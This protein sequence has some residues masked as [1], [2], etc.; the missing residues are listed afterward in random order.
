M[1]SYLKRMPAGIAGAISRP[2]DLTIEPVILDSTNLFAAYGVGGKYS[3]GKF[4]PIASGDT[5]AV[6]A[7]IFVR[8]F[9]TASQPDVVQQI[10]SG[11]NF[12]GDNLKRGYVNVNIGGDASSVTLG[13]AVYM[14]VATSAIGTFVA[15]AD[16]TNTVLISNAYFTGAGDTSGNIEIAFNL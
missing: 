9:P 16:S 8:P 3:G 10:G 4:V 1:T 2:Q 7:G 14:R 12:T 5:A 6:L 11:K 15:A 13:G